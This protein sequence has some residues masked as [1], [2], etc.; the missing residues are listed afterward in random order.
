MGHQKIITF[1][2]FEKFYFVVQLHDNRQLMKIKLSIYTLITFCLLSLTGFSQSKSKAEKDFLKELNDILKETANQHWEFDGKMSID[3]PFAINS[4]GLITSTVKYTTDTSVVRVRSEA[5]V[6]KI[7]FAR[8]DV[9]I[10]LEYRDKSVIVYEQKTNQDWQI[11]FRRNM[12]HIGMGDDDGKQAD[13][14][15][16]KFDKLRE[17]YPTDYN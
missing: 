1:R 7:T 8:Q 5:P 6:N 4:R 3:S 13:K 11:K 15:Q 2:L 17:F 14:V 10:Y 16:Q 12:F 9:Y